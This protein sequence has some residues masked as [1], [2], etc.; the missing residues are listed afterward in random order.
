MSKRKRKTQQSS[1]QRET[2][3][4]HSLIDVCL[5]NTGKDQVDDEDE[6]EDMEMQD[7][8]TRRHFPSI[9]EQISMDLESQTT[10]ESMDLSQTNTSQESMVISQNTVCSQESMDISMDMSNV[11]N[12]QDI[13]S[14]INNALIDESFDIG[15]EASFI[16][17]F[18][19]IN[20]DE[21]S[22]QATK[23]PRKQKLAII[24]PSFTVPSHIVKSSRRMSSAPSTPK[25]SVDSPRMKTRRF[26]SASGI[27]DE[28]APKNLV[29]SPR[30]SRPTSDFFVPLVDSPK[31][32][33]RRNSSVSLAADSPKSV[34]RV[35]TPSKITGKDGEKRADTPKK[36]RVATP[37]KLINVMEYLEEENDSPTKQENVESLVM[38]ETPPVSST[39]KVER[40]V[41]II[42]PSNR[43]TTTPKKEVESVEMKP[44]P[45][46]FTQPTPVSFTQPTPVRSSPRFTPQKSTPKLIPTSI[47]KRKTMGPRL[48]NLLGDFDKDTKRRSSLGGVNLKRESKSPF[49]PFKSSIAPIKSIQSIIA[50]EYIEKPI[51]IT[52]SI[53]GIKTLEEFEESTGISF[54]PVENVMINR[55]LTSYRQDSNKNMWENINGILLNKPKVEY[56][57]NLNNVIQNQISILESEFNVTRETFKTDPP[58]VFDEVCEDLIKV[59]NITRRYCG[60]VAE[61]ENA[62][63]IEDNLFKL[64]K[65]VSSNF[66]GIERDLKTVLGFL[67]R[68]DLMSEKWRSSVENLVISCSEIEDQYNQENL[69]RLKEIE[70]VEIV[71]RDYL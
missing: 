66:D 54:N 40:N 39:P 1:L 12:I 28:D 55:D 14:I 7:T 37:S 11:S 63:M 61:K 21:P 8:F 32:S 53:V 56:F 60:L 17:G 50:P 68:V 6:D 27:L 25:K 4:F 35:G 59:L 45:V 70:E 62:L 42:A 48:L 19:K 3:F 43:N 52:E 5:V 20:L 23:S 30:I 51:P 31:R 2:L 29:E 15:N 58:L 71:T 33:S 26:S 36:S 49:V 44:T 47:A 64:K 10:Q 65:D 24:Q 16:K 13:S 18:F 46:L 34:L 38:I 41:E 67:E 57:S 22:T 9:S 69:K